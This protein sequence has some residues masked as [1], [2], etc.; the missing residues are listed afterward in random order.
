[1]RSFFVACDLG[2]ESGR[3]ML[4]ALHEGALTMSEVRRFP[5]LPAQEQGGMQWNIPELYEE[6]LAG[7]CDIGSY[8]EA[9]RGISCNS[10]A[11]DYLLFDSKGALITPAFHHA[12]PRL[13]EGRN[14]VLARVPLET[15][16]EETGV[17]HAPGSTLFQLGAEKSRRLGRAAHLLP[18][19]DA[20]NY[21]LAGVPRTEMSLAS[22][23]QLWNPLTRTWSRRLLDA[24]DLSPELL[25][26]LV[27]AGT[28][29]GP[30][31]PELAR[32]TALEDAC[33]V[34]SCSHEM[35]AALL[36]LPV[37]P[38]ESWAFLRMG[39][40]AV[41]GA[42]IEE[43]IIS[44]ASRQLNFTNELG[45]GGAVRFSKQT[46]GLWVLEECRRYWKQH[47]REIDDDLLTHLAGSAPAF[48]SLI[49]PNDPRFLTPGDM[50][51]KIQAFCRE[52]NQVVP[53]KPGPIIRCVLESVALLH[54]KTLSELERLTGRNIGCIYLLGGS[55]NA[56][57][58]HFTANA[59][60][61][62]VI[63]VPEDTTAVGN[64]LGQALAL[65]HVRSLDEARQI[66][67]SGAR[68]QKL[69]PYA[70]AWDAAYA[71]LS[72]LISG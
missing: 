51:L 65:G 10:W 63:V 26:P 37:T 5:N 16:Y 46:M 62:L 30:L 71:R 25:P 9:V 56:L 54:R 59:V 15:I 58:N 3:L 68:L 4:G 23:T 18:V 53:R 72:Q 14:R 42:E 13:Q 34:S 28:R 24:V 8:E 33:V 44:E 32:K 27:A 48:E 11:G 52:T 7:L 43:P 38:G 22:G 1:M 2:V 45:Y 64:V 39:S 57:L 66:V 70:A 60:H 40:W 35:A 6:V 36:G 12:D 21:L 69:I 29:L 17:Q 61:R 19:A 20:F 67:R 47:D 50:P 55:A 49:N 31:R 41:M